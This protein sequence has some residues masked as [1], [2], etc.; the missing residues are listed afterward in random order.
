MKTHKMNPIE[1]APLLFA[2]TDK[3]LR[4]TADVSTSTASTY[5]ASTK[6]FSSKASTPNVNSWQS[7]ESDS[8]D[9]SY[10]SAEL[11]DTDSDTDYVPDF[12][13]TPRKPSLVA[14][15][16]KNEHSIDSLLKRFCSCL[17]H[18]RSYDRS[19]YN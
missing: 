2:N 13:A 15:V 10:S 14:K 3:P 18:N 4:S 1:Y 5:K 17:K 6:A 8:G 9:A 19:S 7:P 12:A 11:S 16:S